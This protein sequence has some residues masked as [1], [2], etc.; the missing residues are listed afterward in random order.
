MQEAHDCPTCPTQWAEIY[1]Q[2]EEPPLFS[3]AKN[4][5]AGLLDTASMRASTIRD[6]P[7]GNGRRF[8]DAA[9]V[10][11]PVLQDLLDGTQVIRILNTSEPAV[12]STMRPHTPVIGA[13]VLAQQAQQAVRAQ[14][15][16]VA[17]AG[18]LCR[19]GAAGQRQLRQRLRWQG[20]AQSCQIVV[21][22]VH[23]RNISAAG[24]RHAHLSGHWP[25]APPARSARRSAAAPRR[26]RPSPS[27][28]GPGWTSA[29]GSGPR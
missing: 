29:G 5:G 10:R 9:L 24:T 16:R 4:T 19:A 3:N 18:Q 6:L 13:V 28:P 27:T 12:T 2:R 23:G 26:H 14:R 15:I 25:A 7:P 11:L 22:D 17:Q 20:L 21:D 1:I 8:G